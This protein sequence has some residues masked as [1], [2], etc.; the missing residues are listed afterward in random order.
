MDYNKI[1]AE[2]LGSLDLNIE[3]IL[4]GAQLTIF[5]INYFLHVCDLQMSLIQQFVILFDLVL[6]V[7]YLI[8]HVVFDITE[9]LCIC[10][11]C[12]FLLNGTSLTGLKG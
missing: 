1:V 4:F 3:C 7:G 2:S 8:L 9:I 10:F 6:K 12:G 11:R 5:F